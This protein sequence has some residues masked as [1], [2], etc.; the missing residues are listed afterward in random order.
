MGKESLCISASRGFFCYFQSPSQYLRTSLLK[1][2]H[3]GPK[4]ALYLDLSLLLQERNTQKHRILC[5]NLL[6]SRREGR[7]RKQEGEELILSQF[8]PVLKGKVPSVSSPFCRGRTLALR[9]WNVVAQICPRSAP[10]LPHLATLLRPQVGSLT[11]RIRNV[12]KG[13][14]AVN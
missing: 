14:R 9:D 1:M 5:F 7:G 8:H 4:N 12:C 2:L 13:I 10:P 6:L 11:G 3:K